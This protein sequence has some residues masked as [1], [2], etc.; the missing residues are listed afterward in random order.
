MSKINVEE[1]MQEL[2][3]EIKEKGISSEP[4]TF[5]DVDKAEDHFH[6]PTKYNHNLMRNEL[7]NING[8]WDTSVNPE[9]KASNPV[10]KAIKKIVHKMVYSIVRE[11]VEQQV[12]FNSAMVNAIN[13]L[14][15]LHDENLELKEEIKNLK[16]KI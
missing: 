14:Y 16:A 6:V 10:K 4:L 12:I 8:L 2:R 9:V 11:H 13:M 15:C 7:I 1:I 3:A 5:A